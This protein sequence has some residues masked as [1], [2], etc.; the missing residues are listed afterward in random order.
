MD[1]KSNDKVSDNASE[2]FNETASEEKKDGKVS[3][4]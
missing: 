3:N 4:D 1:T 2:K